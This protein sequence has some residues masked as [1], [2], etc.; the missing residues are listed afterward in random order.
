MPELRK[1]MERGESTA[2]VRDQIIGTGSFR[3]V[4]VQ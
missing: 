1:A 3:E 2:D 4:E